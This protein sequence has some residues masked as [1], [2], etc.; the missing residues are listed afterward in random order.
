[1]GNAENELGQIVDLVDTDPRFAGERKAVE[2]VRQIVE[3]MKQLRRSKRQSQGEI[4]D[5]LGVTQPRISQ[6]ESGLMDHAPNL[7]TIA[8]YAH[9]CGASVSITFVPE[10]RMQASLAEEAADIVSVR[11]FWISARDLRHRKAAQ[12]APVAGKVTIHVPLSPQAA[13][14]IVKA[15]RDVHPG[16]VAVREIGRA[17]AVELSGAAATEFEQT[18]LQGPPPVLAVQDG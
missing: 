1:M 12:E 13:G 17:K 18:L 2:F 11:D 5:A 16:D 14:A 3:G 15:A 10:G 8:K 7:E 4:A 9:A 6:I